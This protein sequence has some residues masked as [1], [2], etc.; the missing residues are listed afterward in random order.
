MQDVQTIRLRLLAHPSRSGSP[1]GRVWLY[2]FTV[3]TIHMRRT[4]KRII[5][6]IELISQESPEFSTPRLQL[7]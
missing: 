2:A 5:M 4:S 6:T 1:K 3:E 7:C